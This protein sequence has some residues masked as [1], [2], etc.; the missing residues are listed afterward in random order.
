MEASGKSGRR[1][2]IWTTA[3]A[4]FLFL[5]PFTYAEEDS[6]NLSEMSV[7]ELMNV[8]VPTINGACK[9]EQKITDAPAAVSLITADEIRKYGYRTLADVL[10][11]VRGFYTTYDRNYHYLGL[12]G[13]NRPGDYNSRVLMLIDGHRINDNLYE[14]AAIGTEFPLDI[15]L[16]D[17]IEIIR[18]PSS[19]LYGTSA[20]FGV[21]NIITRNGK[22]M[23][24]GEVA[25]SAGSQETYN[26]RASY[27][28]K[29]ANGIETLMSGTFYQSGGKKNLYYAAYDAPE[30]NNGIA[31]N[32]DRDRSVSFFAKTTLRD[33]TLTA[34]YVNR[35]KEIPTGSYGALFNDDRNQSLDAHGYVDLKYTLRMDRQD[36]LTARFYLDD[37]RYRGDYIFEGANPGDPSVV[38]R[39]RSDGQWVGGE[40]LYTRRFMQQH[41]VTCGTEGRYNIR[42]DQQNYE[43]GSPSKN[44][45]SSETSH[46]FAFYAQDEYH[47]LPNLIVNVGVRFDKYSNFGSTTN[48]RL[49]LIYKP[50][51]RSIIKLLYG[52]AFRAPNVYEL[53]YGD[54][55]VSQ[56][57][58]PDLKPETIR[59]Y[60][61]VYEQYIGEHLRSSLGGFFYRVHDLITQETD[62]GDGLLIFRNS[63]GSEALGGEAEIEGKWAS[64]F[65]GRLSYTVQKVTDQN[66][67][68]VLTNSPQHLLKFNLIAPVFAKKIFAGLDLQF[69]SRR[70]TLTGNDEGGHVVGNLTLTGRNLIRNTELSVSL[71]NL[72]DAHYADPASGEHT[73]EVI[74]Q[75]GRLVLFKMLYRF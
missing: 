6:P 52:S 67:H 23:K 21:I 69:T 74:E 66:T 73:Q 68:E 2:I 51:D 63:G 58:N 61:I 10:R 24:G 49:A 37:Y 16:I 46:S 59:T 4:V 13:F 48:P 43:D 44:L 25:L 65:Q 36:E 60:E 72:T 54:N 38:D 35:V 56:K 17:R 31:E 12:R 40:L 5:T 39:D 7:E 53:Y 45:D 11:S 26:G 18:G 1:F 20:F 64:G 47:I 50:L 34:A 75:D 57:P 14:T 33:L 15:D 32:S 42:Q 71:Y 27:G 8:D 29:Y 3:L 19:S 22:D 41:L 62:P 9:F 28:T 70:R 30:T 55:G